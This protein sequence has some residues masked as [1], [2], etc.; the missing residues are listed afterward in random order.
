MKLLMENWRSYLA[1]AKKSSKAAAMIG[2]VLG[3]AKYD[4]TAH[5]K[6][7][8]D[9][10]DEGKID[11]TS[12]WKINDHNAMIEKFKA[13]ECFHVRLTDN[14]LQ[15][16]ADYFVSLPSEIAMTLWQ[17]MG[18]TEEATYNVAK[19]HS[20]STSSG[21]KVQDFIVGILTAK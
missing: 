1:E 4:G 20:I 14:Q 9:I 18:E 2:D 10:L 11:L 19:L 13:K 6:G 8:E 15:N 5:K 16:L 7:F 12:D 21:T 3:S 17:A